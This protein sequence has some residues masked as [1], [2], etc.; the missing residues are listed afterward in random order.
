[1]PHRMFRHKHATSGA[2][3]L[4][5]TI[6]VVSLSYAV[7]AQ[8]TTAPSPITSA[9]NQSDA[10]DMVRQQILNTNTFSDQAQRIS[11]FI[12]AADLLWPYDQNEARAAFG[13]AFDLA[14]K[15]FKEKGDE[16]KSLA[17][18]LLVETPDQRFLVIRA[19]A[20]HDSAWAKR[21]TE[22][23]L[24]EDRDKTDDLTAKNDQT[25]LRTAWKLLDLASSLIS[26][27]TNTAL[28]YAR[29]SLRYPASTRLTVFLYKLA[30]VDQR[31]A[32]QFFLEA[33]AAYRNKPAR[34][35]LYLVAYP[36][37]R[38]DAGSMPW[39]GSYTVPASFSPNPSVQRSF[40]S[41][42]LLR[43]QQALVTALDEGDNYN[44]FPGI[45]HFL[46]QLIA[47]QPEI[48]KR[49]PDLVT[50]FEQTRMNLLAALSPEDQAALLTPKS[51]TEPKPKRTFEQQVEAA[52]KEPSVNKRDELIVTAILNAT[53][54]ESLDR[55]I[56]VADKLSDSELRSQLTDWLFFTS[57]QRAIKDGR[58]NEAKTFASRVKPM[59]QRAYLYSEIAKE[60]LRAAENQNQARELLEEIVEIAGKSPKTVVS[61]RA[62]FSA[63][64]LYLKID[65][66]RAISILGA[67]VNDI[68][69]IDS[70][71]FSRQSFVRKIEGKT[72]ARS[73]LFRT[74]GF[75]PENAFVE[76]GKI[77]FDDACLGRCLPAK[78]KATRKGREGCQKT[79]VLNCCY[80]TCRGT[81]MRLPQ[82][83]PALKLH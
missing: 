82:L 7:A 36:F 33:L 34:E 15:N 2:M 38:D 37:G 6:W 48:P 45:G 25:D 1:M 68:N 76:I 67:A 19:V 29:A 64:Y 35:F 63:A 83:E 70:P 72:F 55:L 49:L 51:Q 4:L 40:T 32:D 26:S 54:A 30:E 16:L 10:I 60:F 50:N 61:S 22:Q 17:R 9:C 66:N 71:D 74:P 3:A 13:D 56:N 5:T 21:L 57:T 73:A 65:P 81:C 11:V 23:M 69:H 24:K 58:L 62:L 39:S 31:A 44:G 43:A 8:S 12:R 77:A 42:F 18:G 75:D 20:K 59:D 14:K 79:E 78:D 47:I 27:D 28:T 80:R 46:E 41:T 52:E 53:Q